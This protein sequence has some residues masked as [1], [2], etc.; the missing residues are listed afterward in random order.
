MYLDPS[1]L[2]VT[3]RLT[4][5]SCEPADRADFIA[6]ELDPLVMH[7]L[8]G[9]AVDHLLTD[10]AAQ[11]FLMPRGT[12]PY[13]WTARLTQTEEFVG[14]FSLVPSGESCAELGFRLRSDWWGKGYATEG[15]AALA[16]WA[17]RH[18]GYG[19]ITA[20]TMAVNG[21]SRRVMEKIGMRHVRTEFVDFPDPIPGSEYGEVVYELR[22]PV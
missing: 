10:P 7:Y 4:L 22:L 14:W 18:E 17:L 8:N 11:P 12:E 19:Y 9:G 1:R 2:L 21:A 3:D 6:L 5:R 13:V 16:R 20:T 15:A